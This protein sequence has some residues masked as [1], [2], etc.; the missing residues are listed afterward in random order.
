MRNKLPGPLTNIFQTN[1]EVHTYRTRNRY[2]PR[3]D[4]HRTTIFNNSFLSKGP[5]LWAE[6]PYEI[7]NNTNCIKSFAH[8]IKKKIKLLLIKL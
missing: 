4:L 5:S 1:N 8:K 3:S 6:L 7:K 2:D